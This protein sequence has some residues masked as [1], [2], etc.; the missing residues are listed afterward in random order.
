MSKG[1]RRKF[2]REFKHEAVRLVTEAG[3]PVAEVARDLGIH[4]NQI[5]R[6]KQQF[7]E[8]P[9]HAFPGQGRLKPYDEE[10]RQ[11][12]RELASVKQQRDILKKALAIFSKPPE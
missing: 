5:R 10:V 12:R 4:E 9:A 2:D 8:D 11:L 6:W 3:R 1:R 7:L